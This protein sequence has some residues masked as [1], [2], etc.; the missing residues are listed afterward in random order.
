MALGDSQFK[1]AG[2]SALLLDVWAA[3]YPA[4][5]EVSVATKFFQPGQIN[6]KTKPAR[7]EAVNGW[8]TLRMPPADFHDDK[9]AALASWKEVDFLWL[10]GTG[11]GVKKTVFKNLRREK[12]D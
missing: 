3:D 11:D 8:I 9:G 4:T 7:G 10:S 6:Y 12:L 5:L 2:T 1:S